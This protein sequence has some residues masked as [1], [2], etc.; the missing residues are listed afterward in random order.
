[1]AACRSKAHARRV[2]LRRHAVAL[3]HRRSL[4]RPTDNL[5]EIAEMDHEC[6]TRHTPCSGTTHF[7]ETAVRRRP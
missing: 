1:M 5:Y 4:R 7:D 2:S 6:H 3:C